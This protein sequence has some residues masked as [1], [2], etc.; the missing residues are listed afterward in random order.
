MGVFLNQRLQLIL[1]I[2]IHI[3]LLKIKK[4]GMMKKRSESG[5]SM[6]EMLAVLVIFVMLSLL[7]IV[8]F[9]F[10]KE[11]QQANDLMKEVINIYNIARTKG[12]NTTTQYERMDVPKGVTRMDA[13]IVEKVVLIYHNPDDI[14]EGVIKTI[15]NLYNYQV[16]Q[17][18]ITNIV[19]GKKQEYNVLKVHF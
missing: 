7:G 10:M 3:L 19:N 1:F 16:T 8:G 14:T 9:D 5:R 4:G 18:V 17:E 15:E 13:K 6:V 12:H 2:H 11:R